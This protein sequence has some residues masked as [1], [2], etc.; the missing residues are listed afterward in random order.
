MLWQDSYFGGVRGFP[1]INA[2]TKFSK[3]RKYGG[4]KSA[5]PQLMRS[6]A[7]G[8]HSSVREREDLIWKPL[9]EN[10]RLIVFDK[11]P[12]FEIKGLWVS[13]LEEVVNDNS[14]INIDLPRTRLTH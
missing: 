4:D 1:D 11:E 10:M 13:P 14:R 6:L 3:G 12:A 9:K 5:P 7:Q 2:F 8:N